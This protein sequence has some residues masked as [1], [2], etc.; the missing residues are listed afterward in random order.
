[1]GWA[2]D[3]ESIRQTIALYC[4]LLDDQRFDELAQLFTL[5]A[6]LPWQGRTLHGRGE[7]A[8]EMHTTQE[9]LGRTRHLPFGSVID[10]TGDTARS[11]TETAVTLN[12]PDGSARIAW[13]GRY[14]DEFR[15]EDDAWRFAR[16]V[17]LSVGEQM[18]DGVTP[19]CLATRA[20]H[21][22]ADRPDAGDRGP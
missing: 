15:F 14:H 5:D 13:L 2:D 16:H 19:V 22:G 8:R 6:E 18:P 1:M 21:A 12:E 4:Q 3:C 11:W 10:V 20:G 7:I 9:P 17:A